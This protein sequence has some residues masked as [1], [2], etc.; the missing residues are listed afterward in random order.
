MAEMQQMDTIQ[1]VESHISQIKQIKD[2]H[3]AKHEASDMARYI[4][5]RTSSLFTF[6]C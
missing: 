6:I 4:Q 5:V 2:N 3:T 1:Q